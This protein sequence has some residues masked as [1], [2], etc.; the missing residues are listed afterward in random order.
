[1]SGKLAEI[2][3]MLSVLASACL[4]TA[5]IFLGAFE[6][7]RMENEHELKMKQIEIDCKKEINGKD[8]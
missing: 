5:L 6:A 1:M 3:G 7:Q 8:Y 2:A 4:L